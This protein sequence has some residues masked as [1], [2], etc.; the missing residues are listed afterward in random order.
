M[1]VKSLPQPS[2]VSARRLHEGM[3]EERTAYIVRVRGLLAESGLPFPRRA[4]ALRRV[5]PE[6]LHA[7][8]NGMS[9]LSRLAL[10]RAQQQSEELDAHLHW[11][12]ERAGAHLKSDAQA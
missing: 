12:D 6:V 1:R 4:Q 5:L 2:V 8:G 10:Q 9:S 11:Y 3:Q 7:A